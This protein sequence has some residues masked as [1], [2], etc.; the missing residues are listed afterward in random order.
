M[1]KTE[2]EKLREVLQECLDGKWADARGLNR[3]NWR[4]WWVENAGKCVLCKSEIDSGTQFC[5]AGGHKCILKDNPSEPCEPCCVEYNKCSDAYVSYN[6]PAFQHAVLDM[7]SR[8]QLEI[9]KLEPPFKV[10]NLT[11]QQTK[12][13]VGKPETFSWL[14]MLREQPPEG[15]EVFFVNP[16]PM[17]KPQQ[18]RGWVWEALDRDKCDSKWH[19]IKLPHAIGDVVVMKHNGIDFG[20]HKVI[21]V[22]VCRVSEI[23]MNEHRLLE[24]YSKK[25]TNGYIDYLTVYA[26]PRPRR[27]NGEIVWY[28]CWVYNDGRKPSEPYYSYGKDIYED[29][30]VK[31]IIREYKGKLL[32]IHANPFIVLTKGERQ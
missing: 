24:N 13:L 2:I 21:S 7:C 12:R 1:K 28:E 6:F 5:G 32:K 4:D 30:T 15:A 8:L 18:Y 29:L 27:K 17:V 20:G 26:K 10:M 14:S 16:N 23:T 19:T 31:P 11:K 3:E 25:T 22:K 9:D